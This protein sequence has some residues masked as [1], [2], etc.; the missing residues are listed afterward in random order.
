MNR[1]RLPSRPG[2][3]SLT[4]ADAAPG[5]GA[6]SYSTRQKSSSL[7]SSAVAVVLV[8]AIYCCSIWFWSSRLCTRAWITLPRVSSLVDREGRPVSVAKRERS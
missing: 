3:A 2:D 8:A 6:Y 7:G 5:S 4:P 1:S